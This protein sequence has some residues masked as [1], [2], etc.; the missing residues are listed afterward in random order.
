VRSVVI[1]EKETGKDTKRALRD[2]LREF[3]REKGIHGSVNAV[4][5]A[6]SN[7]QTLAQ[8]FINI[9]DEMDAPDDDINNIGMKNTI[10][11]SWN[12]IEAAMKRLWQ[13]KRQWVELADEEPTIQEEL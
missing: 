7:K 12:E 3:M 4:H 2:A 8:I 5:L 1:A 11:I 10:F 9:P 6:R 13:V